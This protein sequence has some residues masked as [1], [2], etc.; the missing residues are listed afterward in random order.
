M[1]AMSPPFR[2]SRLPLPPASHRPARGRTSASGLGFH[3]GTIFFAAYLFNILIYFAASK[4]FVLRPYLPVVT[5]ALLFA[6]VAWLAF[7]RRPVRFS[8][9]ALIPLAWLG[10]SALSFIVA[11][12]AQIDLFAIRKVFLPFTALSVFFWRYATSRKTLYLC[13]PLVFLIGITLALQG[14]SDSSFD[15]DL[16]ST[17]ADTESVFGIFFGAAVPFF[18]FRGRKLSAAMAFV[19]C[20]IMFKRNAILADILIGLLY[21]SSVRTI[22]RESLRKIIDRATF[23]I[24]PVLMLVSYNLLAILKFLLPWASK[25]RLEYI[26]TGRSFIWTYVTQSFQHS[27]VLELLFGHGPGAV[28]RVLAGHPTWVGVVALSHNEY[29][30]LMYDFGFVGA[31]AFLYAFRA[32]C[33]ESLGAS[34]IFLYLLLIFLVE[35]VFF[36]SLPLMGIAFLASAWINPRLARGGG[37]SVAPRAGNRRPAIADGEL[38]LARNRSGGMTKA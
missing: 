9:A 10:V 19:A 3:S 33:R 14:L 6:H 35:N 18:L 15:A 12:K 20:F 8:K 2:P 26:T 13:L 25:S 28:E 22:G 17:N 27:S 11:D 23:F 31:A 36:M 32:A 21:F 29:L 37:R 38:R 4:E 34:A 16:L 1:T 7:A 5:P 30:S 24:I